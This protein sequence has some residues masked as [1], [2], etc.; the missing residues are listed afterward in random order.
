MS[1]ALSPEPSTVTST[2]FIDGLPMKPA[3]KRLSGVS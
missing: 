2:K 1:R 3:T